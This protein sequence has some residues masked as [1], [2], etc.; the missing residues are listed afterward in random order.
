MYLAPD[1]KISGHIH[2]RPK[3]Q[4][5]VKLPCFLITVATTSNFLRGW[6]LPDTKYM[7][8]YGLL[9]QKQCAEACDW[10]DGSYGRIRSLALWHSGRPVRPHMVAYGSFP[11][12]DVTGVWGLIWSHTVQS[13]METRPSC[14]G[15]YGH[16]RSLPLWRRGRPVRAHMVAYGR[17]SYGAVA[18]L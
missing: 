2:G 9:C 13:S 16:I 7:A 6:T 3:F 5:S 18:G 4:I 8:S 1:I 12:G 17:L 10:S 15:S 11:S 14:G